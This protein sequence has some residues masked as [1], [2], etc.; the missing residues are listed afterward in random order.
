MMGTLMYI[1]KALM[2][3][4]PNV[5]LIA[6]FIA[7]FTIVYRAKALFPIYVFVFL[8]G[9]MNGFNTWWIPYLYI[10]AVLW[11][12][13]MLLPKSIPNKIKPFVY[14]GICALH[15]LLY[16]TLYAPFQAFF[17]GL[18]FKGMIAWIVAGL[19]WDAVHAAG[20]LVTGTLIIPLAKLLENIEKR[21]QTGKEI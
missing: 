8:T 9:L 4:L 20:N 1:S 7:V 16:G 15:G 13:L 18:S 19:P 6:T 11:G 21:L 14:M 5:H 17:Y 10:W 2:E 3:F 12:A